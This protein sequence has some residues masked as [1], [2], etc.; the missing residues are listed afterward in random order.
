MM[1]EFIQ[2]YSSAERTHHHQSADFAY[3]REMSRA[4][5]CSLSYCFL[6]PIENDER[7]RLYSLLYIHLL[8]Q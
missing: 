1:V 6:L 3:K 8:D 4:K 5:G 2:L 7:M